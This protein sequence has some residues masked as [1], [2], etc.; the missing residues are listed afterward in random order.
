MLG[1]DKTVTLVRYGDDERY[2]CTVIHGASWFSKQVVAVSEDGAKPVNM[3]QCR[4][5][6]ENMPA[7]LE[8]RAGDNLVLGGL[9]AVERLADLEGRTYFQITAVGDNR[10]GRLSHWALSGG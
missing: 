6:A 3:L 7:G 5:P 9:E 1:C 10:R 4:I 2:A 8:P